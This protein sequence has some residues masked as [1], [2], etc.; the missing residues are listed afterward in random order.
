MGKRCIIVT[1]PIR[2]LASQLNVNPNVFA[3]WIGIWQS[4]NNTDSMPDVPSLQSLMESLKTD[5]DMQT[6]IAN[7]KLVNV[8]TYNGYWTRDLV[9]KDKDRVYL[10]GD[11]TED[12]V[13]THHIPSTTQA[14]I[15]GLPNAIG[16][17]TKKNR[18]TSEGSVLVTK[19][20]SGG[21]TGV[22]TLG[23]QVAK[24]LGIATGGTTPKGFLRESN[25]DTEN[26]SSYGLVE[27][28]EK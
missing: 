17:D 9:N 22:D 25:I 3:T 16:I 4:R 8:E 27:I 13:N 15:R 1:K 5:K 23:L 6:V 18:G 7:S 2:E 20:I 28:T 11:N 19:I 10:F 12:R 14:V 21:Q 24:T 26:I